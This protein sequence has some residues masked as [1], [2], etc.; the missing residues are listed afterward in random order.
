MTKVDAAHQTGWQLVM[1]YFIV[2]LTKQYHAKDPEIAGNAY[3]LDA[4]H[5]KVWNLKFHSYGWHSSLGFLFSLHT[6]KT[7]FASEQELLAAWE[8]FD[9]PYHGLL[10]RGIHCCTLQQVK[11]ESVCHSNIVHHAY[12]QCYPIRNT[13]S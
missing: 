6:G 4:R 10:L 7:K 12:K 8:V 13:D 2:D 1:T 5:C 3:Y 11:A 9:L